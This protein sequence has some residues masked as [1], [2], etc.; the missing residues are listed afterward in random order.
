MHRPSHVVTYGVVGLAGFGIAYDCG[1][2]GPPDGHDHSAVVAI[3][4]SPGS[5][6]LSNGSMAYVSNG[7]TGEEIAVFLPLPPRPTQT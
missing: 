6:G 7:V 5:L 2:F 1:L 4:P 3:A